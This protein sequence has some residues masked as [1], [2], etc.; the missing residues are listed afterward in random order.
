[1]PAYLIGGPFMVLALWGLQPHQQL[2]LWLAALYGVT[3]MR[4]L[5][6]RHFNRQPLTPDR[7]RYWRLVAVA[8]AFLTGLVLGSSALFFVDTTAPV[9]ILVVAVAIM[10]TT[11]SAVAVLAPYL[12]V[13]AALVLPSMGTL[14]VV[15]LT[16]A[17]L[18]TNFVGLVSV[19]TQISNSVIG[20]NLHR[21]MQASVRLSFENQ[22]LMRDAQQADVAKTRFLAAASHDLRQPLHALGLFIATLVEKVRSP[23]TSEVI[24][25]I[26][27][28]LNNVNGMLNTLLDVS[29]LDA[30]VVKINSSDIDLQPMFDRLEKECRP[31]ALE[32]HNRL[33]FHPT[34]LRVTTD[35]GLFERILRNLLSNA[36]RY[37]HGGGVLVT[38]RK[39]GSVVV[40]GVYDTGPGIPDE[41]QQEIFDEFHQLSNPERDS[42]RG[43]GLGLAIVRR[44][45]ALLG[46][47]LALRSTLGKGSC[48]FISLPPAQH[49][50]QCSDDA[51]QAGVEADLSGLTV[52]VID[53]D[54]IVATAVSALLRGWG[55]QVHCCESLEGALA[56]AAQ[57][58]VTPDLLLV[59][60]RLRDEV[61]GDMVIAAL[62]RRIGRALPAA[63]ITGDTAPQRLRDATNAGYP[64]L[65]KPVR[66]ETLRH[67]IQGLLRRG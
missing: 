38:A 67:T 14:I 54:A 15:L 45:A 62:H 41:Q 2:L 57:N 21:A 26:D 8:T 36:L 18:A 3:G 39:R 53:D 12:P 66:P 48:F 51:G 63:I 47:P 46:H 29:R 13:Y 55:C 1:M 60:Y 7:L 30:G 22:Q 43:L 44:T 58:A 16:D 17:E 10:S 25:Q 42:R 34:T 19:M 35:A 23:S 37:T 27:G 32:N 52:L 4:A 24:A 31:M 5:I 28:S 61:T 59:D 56:I 11:S 40:C 20:V 50:A 9:T 6:Y 65:H 64:L 33:R 49:A